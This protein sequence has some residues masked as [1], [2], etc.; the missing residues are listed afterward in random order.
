MDSAYNYAQ[1]S[2]AMGKFLFEVTRPQENSTMTL[3]ITREIG[4][5]KN[6]YYNVDMDELKRLGYDGFMHIKGNGN[7]Y[8]SEIQIGVGMALS[9]DVNKQYAWDKE[10][11]ICNQKVNYYC[12]K[13][14]VG[15]V[16]AWVKA[17]IKEQGE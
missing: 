17:W 9:L 6:N 16:I 5:Y 2:K 14:W 3:I 10:D 4:E 1:R 7:S 11:V 8:N 13:G 15:S 12:S